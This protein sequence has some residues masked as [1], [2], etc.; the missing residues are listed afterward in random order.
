MLKY[1]ARLLFIAVIVLLEHALILDRIPNYLLWGL[2]PIFAV[3][4]FFPSAESRK[5]ST[6]RL[7]C[8]GNGCE[9]LIVFVVTTSLSVVFCVSGMLGKL[10]TIGCPPLTGNTSRWVVT[11]LLVVLCEATVFWNGIIRVYLTSE[12]LGFRWRVLGVAVGLIPILNLIMLKI[13]VSVAL[14]EIRFE[15]ARIRLDNERAEQKLCQTKYPLLLVHGVFFR[16][17]RY[18]NYWGRIPKSLQSNGATIYYG[19]HQSAA[20]VEECAQ[21]LAERI[22]QIVE[23]T[24]CEKLNVIAHSK[25]GLDIRYALAKC[26]VAEKVAS[27]TTINTP[28]RGCEFADY[29]LNKIPEKEQQAIAVTYNSALKKMGDT[30]PDFLAA[31]GD[32]T[33]SAC[34]ARNEE[35]DDQNGVYYQS[36][37][38]KLNVAGSGRFPLNFTYRLVK[39]FDGANDGLVGEK[40]FSW[41]EDYRFLTV[42]GKRGVSHGDIIDLNRENIPQF[43]VREFFVQLVHT[44][45]EKGF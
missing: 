12:Q 30:N 15:D 42:E 8:L 1:F 44:L 13:I 21:E 32:L 36:I 43:D 28:H 20:S 31:V 4:Q 19:N 24:G 14:A 11:V 33:A 25:G 29:L 3:F 7:R 34:R 35:I 39:L 41:G 40:S 27:L 45:K 38:S 26:G 10:T 5:L 17:F 18:F 9:L 2:I 22:V 23:E 16:D 37:G 6:R